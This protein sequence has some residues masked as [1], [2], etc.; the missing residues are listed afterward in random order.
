MITGA[1][2][3]KAAFLS[4]QGEGS[5]ARD[6]VALLREDSDLFGY[7]DSGAIFKDPNEQKTTFSIHKIDFI[8]HC[9]NDDETKKLFIEETLRIIKVPN[10]FLAGFLIKYIY[11]IL[12]GRGFFSEEQLL[13]LH[14]PERRYNRFLEL[15]KD[16]SSTKFLVV[17]WMGS[18]EEKACLYKNF[19]LI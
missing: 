13:F 15:T 3:S 11:P 12:S 4:S 1:G 19:S 5:L 9:L 17:P 18:I 7:H 2:K 14:N 8:A 6:T 16:I 10:I